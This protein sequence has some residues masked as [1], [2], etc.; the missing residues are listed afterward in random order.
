MA[1]LYFAPPAKPSEILGGLRNL[2]KGQHAMLLAMLFPEPETGGRGKNVAAR[3]AV[4]NTGFSVER[5]KQAR[6]V[7]HH[8][9]SLAESVLKGI[10]VR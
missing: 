10:T 2:N 4:L 8:S 9:R 6:S 5:L 7:L 1:A 3:K